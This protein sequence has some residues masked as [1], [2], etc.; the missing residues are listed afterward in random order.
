MATSGS[1]DFSLSRDNLIKMAFQ[2]LGVVAVGGTPSS[3]QVTEAALLLN[4]IVKS[5]NATFGIPLFALSYAYIFPA[6]DDNSIHLA[7]DGDHATNANDDGL[8]ITTLASDHST[9]DS[10][11]DLESVSNIADNNYIGIE[12]DAGTIHWTQVNGAP[13]GNIVTV[14]TGITSAAAEGNRVFSYQTRLPRPLRITHAY[15][16]N[17]DTSIDTPIEIITPNEYLAY[18]SKLQDGGD[19]PLTLAYS[20]EQGRDAVHLWPCFHNFDYVVIIQYQSVI[21]DFDADV[22]TPDFPQEYYLAAVME[23]ACQLAPQ[24]GV[25]V[26]RQM[27][28]RREADKHLEKVLEN[29]YHEGSI[30]FEPNLSSWK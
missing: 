2:R 18:T 23:L 3:A 12:L 28:L 17:I 21:E 10:T 8:L 1:T 11:I 5:W 30:Y 26:N 13:A 27:W 20:V 4:A 24:Y 9:S 29:D 25:D 19:Y 14:D 6:I 22:N 16:H 7:T 15:A